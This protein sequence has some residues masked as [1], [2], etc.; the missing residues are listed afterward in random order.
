MRW[1]YINNPKVNWRFSAEIFIL[2]LLFP[3]FIILFRSSSI[4]SSSS[5][6]N[7][8]FRIDGAA[9]SYMLN[10]YR[11]SPI[12]RICIYIMYI[13]IHILYVWVIFCLLGI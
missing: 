5:S 10:M 4:S 11:G 8:R 3:I 9:A 12:F 7:D 13:Y 6:S 2:S 1:K